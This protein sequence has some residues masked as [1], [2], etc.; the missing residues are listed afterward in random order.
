MR[1]IALTLS[2][3][4]ALDGS[5]ADAQLRTQTIASGLGAIVGA[6]PIQL[7]RA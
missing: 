2:M 6:R 3:L 1:R 7:S 4:L 5:V